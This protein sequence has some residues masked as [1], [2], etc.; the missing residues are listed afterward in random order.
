MRCGADFDVAAA[1]EF[2]REGTAVE[3]FLAPP[4]VVVGAEKQD[5]A[6]RVAS[7]FRGVDGPLSIASI[8]EAE[9]VKYASNAWHGLKIA[10]ANEIGAYC[11]RLKIDETEVMRIFVED[12]KLNLSARYLTPGFAFGGPCLPKDI[13]ALTHRA[14]EIGVA[15]PVVSSI[16]PSNEGRIE[17]QLQTIL[18]TGKRAIG[19]LGVSNKAESNDLR[20]SPYLE[21][22]RRLLARG[23][24]LRIFDPFVAQSSLAGDASAYLAEALPLATHIVDTLEE[25][26][27]HGDLIVV[28][29]HHRAL[30]DIRRRLRPDQSVLDL[31]RGFV[32]PRQ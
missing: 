10:F 32:E 4:L 8:E 26:L 24:D 30:H 13:E 20:A 11:R 14:R 22:C 9:M 29:T 28:G 25:V 31:A 17:E 27:R 15:L 12:R 2:L 19:V 18:R 5:V 3:D 1:P 23:C 7:L 21:L 16:L 6:K